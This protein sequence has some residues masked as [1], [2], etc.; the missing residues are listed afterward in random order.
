[1]LA[2]VV[3]VVCAPEGQSKLGLNAVAKQNRKLYFG[4]AT[5]N[6]EFTNDTSYLNIIKDSR[7]FGQLTAANSMKWVSLL[8]S[9]KIHE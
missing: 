3:S 2:L 5:N 6:E 1:M 9:T 4:T 8:F 7:M